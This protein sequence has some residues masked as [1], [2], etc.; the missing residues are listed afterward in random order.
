MGTSYILLLTA[1][2]VDNG[3]KPAALERAAADRLLAA[4]QRD[5]G[6][7]YPLCPTAASGRHK[8][9]PPHYPR[10]KIPVL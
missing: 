3:K 1:F 8:F 6:A 4:A 2:Y 7:Y 5:R 10:I 9:K